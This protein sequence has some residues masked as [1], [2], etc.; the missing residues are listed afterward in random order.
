MKGSGAPDL[1]GDREG[2]CYFADAQG[3]SWRLPPAGLTA[4]QRLDW[5]NER[6]TATC[7]VQ[8]PPLSEEE[9]GMSFAAL[10]KLSAQRRLE[11]ANAALAR[12][13][14]G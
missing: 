7:R 13:S 5:A 3:N 10:S 14:G 6:A 2:E 9:L 8:E 1:C 11:I 12:R 4:R